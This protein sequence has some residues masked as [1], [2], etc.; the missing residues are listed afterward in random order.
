MCIR[1]RLLEKGVVDAIVAQRQELFTN[2]AIRKIY[3]YE[4]GNPETGVELLDTYEIN[5]INV[6]ALL[7][8]KKE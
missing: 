7:A 3:S 6:G 2:I 5:K 8:L 4:A 1:D